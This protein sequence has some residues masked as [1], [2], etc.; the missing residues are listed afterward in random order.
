[1]GLEADSK[2]AELITTHANFLKLHNG[3]FHNWEGCE[4]QAA[5]LC[6]N[7]FERK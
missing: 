5:A 4:A 2:E 6:F 1:M 7:Y 3:K